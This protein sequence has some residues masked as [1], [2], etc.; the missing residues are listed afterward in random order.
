M[1]IKNAVLK[2][3]LLKGLLVL[4]VFLL[5]ISIGCLN[6]DTADPLTKEERL[7]LSEHDGKIR[8]GHDPNAKPI[9]YIDK[10]GH[11]QGLAADYV[12]LIEN[13]LNF[14]FDILRIKTWD[15][16]LKK[17]KT[18]DVDVLCAFSKSQS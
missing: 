8:L 13:R 9:D 11:F 14:K 10:N 7:W 3:V 15:E 12:H 4:S 1:H 5:F 6:K 2:S 18:K 16:V 17:A